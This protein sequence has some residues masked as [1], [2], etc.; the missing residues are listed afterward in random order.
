MKV[1][2][3]TPEKRLFTGEAKLIQ[4]PGANGSF[5]IMN[6]HAPVISTLF[7]GKIKVVE[8]SGNKLFFEI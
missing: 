3:I 8:L 2:I 5:E 4:L 7:E 1:E 6:N